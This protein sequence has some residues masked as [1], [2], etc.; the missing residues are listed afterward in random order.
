MIGGVV[1][2]TRGT[3]GRRTIGGSSGGSRDDA[4]GASGSEEGDVW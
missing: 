4:R 2:G 3:S 1:S